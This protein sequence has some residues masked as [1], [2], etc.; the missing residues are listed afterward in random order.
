MFGVI[1][2]QWRLFLIFS[3]KSQ[4]E[5]HFFI[6]SHCLWIYFQPIILLRMQSFEGFSPKSLPYTHLRLHLVSLLCF[7][8]SR[9]LDTVIG[10]CPHGNY[11]FYI[12][13]SLFF[14]S[15][16]SFRNPIF[17]MLC[18]LERSAVQTFILSSFSR[19][20]LEESFII[21]IVVY[22]TILIAPFNR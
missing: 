1:H 22:S 18:F 15:F 6:V 19:D 12:H 13:S 10:K 9:L 8:S 2:S 17:I 14:P 7:K 4:T 11:G 16:S 5:T 3:S 20:F 21:V